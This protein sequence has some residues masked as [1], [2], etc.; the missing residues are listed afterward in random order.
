MLT[1]HTV[2][3]KPHMHGVRPP[4]YDSAHN[5]VMHCSSDNDNGSVDILLPRR[6]AGWALCNI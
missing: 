5:W 1:D 4:E 3:G 2:T 6:C